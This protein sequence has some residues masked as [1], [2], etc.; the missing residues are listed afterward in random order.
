M[1]LKYKVVRMFAALLLC[2]LA[3]ADSLAFPLLPAQAA[4]TAQAKEKKTVTVKWDKSWTYAKESKIH[5]GSAKLYYASKKRKDIVVCVNAGHGTKGGESKKTYCHPDHSA[6]VTGG[7]TAK[8]STMATAI[9]SGTTMSDKTP[10]AKAT[11]ALAK[12][13]KDKLLE[14]G[15]DVL[16]L[17]ESDDVQL[18]NIARTVMANNK[19]D[20]HIALHYDGTNSD[21]GA[22]YCGVPNNKT[23]RAMS[24]VKEH[25]KSHEQLGKCL[26]KGLEAKKVKINASLKG[27]LEVDLTQTSYSTIPSVDLEVGTRVS[28]RDSGSLKKIANGIVA[29]LDEFMGK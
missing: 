22:F 23:Y 18:D 25:W 13:V 14:A 24:P 6:K 29:G 17:R 19:A 26:I 11:L 1:E 7:S 16:M 21:T 12:V 15:Y 20:C 9:A 8:G 2:A 10:E 28:K 4:K 27:R 3:L 5:S